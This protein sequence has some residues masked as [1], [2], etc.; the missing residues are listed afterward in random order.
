MHLLYFFTWQAYVIILP[1]LVIVVGIA[2]GEISFDD[3]DVIYPSLGNIDAK[4][5]DVH[6][7]KT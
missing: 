2:I 1:L 5:P 4:P 6:L 7:D 3:K